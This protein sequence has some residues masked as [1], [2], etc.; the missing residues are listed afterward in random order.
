MCNSP[1]RME[2]FMK[3]KRTLRIII[4][5]IIFA[6]IFILAIVFSLLKD[7]VHSNPV[8]TIG[9]TA[10]NLNNAGLFCERDGIVYFANGYDNSTLYSM[11]VDETHIKKLSSARI[12]QI[13]AGSDNLYYFQ[14]GSGGNAGLGYVRTMT[15]LYRTDLK[16]KRS[17]CFNDDT[18]FNIQLVNDTLYYLMSDN[19]GSHFYSVATNN[20]NP[21]LLSNSIVNPSC[22]LDSTIYYNGTENDHFLYALDTITGTASTVWEGNLWN[23]IV[24]GD[25]VYYMDVANNYRLCRYSF[26]NDQIEVLTNDRIDFYNMNDTYIYYQRSSSTQPALIRMAL[27][28]SNVEIVQEGIFENINLTSQYVYFNVFDTP[29]PIYKTPVNGPIAVTTFDAAREAAISN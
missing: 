18:I 5:S 28:G 1:I 13:N 24:S 19:K 6:L 25:Y 14:Y 22:V 20:S 8:G 15:G 16:G 2:I 12:N 21:I 3:S 4:I 10:G 9:N 23:P 26:S 27:D 11:N 17:I 7:R 29:A